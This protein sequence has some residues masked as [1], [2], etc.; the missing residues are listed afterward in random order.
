MQQKKKKIHRKVGF[1]LPPF[2]IRSG[3][4]IKKGKKK[5]SVQYF[6]TKSWN[7]GFLA[8][9]VLCV[10]QCVCCTVCAPWPNW[11]HGFWR[12]ESCSSGSKLITAEFSALVHFFFFHLST[13]VSEH[14]VLTLLRLDL[15]IS[16]KSEQFCG[17]AGHTLLQPVKLPITMTASPA[18]LTGLPNSSYTG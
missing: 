18:S 8:N 15:S 12:F 13:P 10:R 5:P 3:Q 1:S 2:K 7:T 6:L 11:H 4:M 9:A 14:F 16:N 17:R